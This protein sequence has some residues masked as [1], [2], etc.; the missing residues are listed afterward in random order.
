MRFLH[1]QR[2]GGMAGG[3]KVGGVVTALGFFLLG[4]AAGY[5]VWFQHEGV[6]GGIF[7]FVGVF[8]LLPAAEAEAI[9][10]APVGLG[11]GGV[12]GWPP[13]GP[14]AVGAREAALPTARLRPR[15]ARRSLDN[16]SRR[17]GRPPCRPGTRIR[18]TPPRRTPRRNPGTPSRPDGRPCRRRGTGTAARVP[19]WRRGPR[20]R[21]ASIRRGDPSC[22]D[23]PPRRSSTSRRSRAGPTCLP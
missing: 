23:G 16:D 11:L 8:F 6:G 2:S 1:L 5:L 20:A 14:W 19:P 17:R 7:Y 15:S 10:G 3:F 21:P 12:G 4:A 22:S 9:M 18:W 13:E